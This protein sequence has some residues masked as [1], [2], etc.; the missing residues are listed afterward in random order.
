MIL[1]RRR[2]LPVLALLVV[3]GCRLVDQTTF[4]KE[5]G[6]PPVIP[7]VPSPPPA[8]PE[9]PPALLTIPLSPE[10]DWAGVLRQAVASAVQRKPT[11]V[12]DVAAIVPA[13]GTPEEQVA[14][15]TTASE[16]ASRIARA[17]E[18]AGIPPARVNLSARTAAGLAASEVR[19]YVR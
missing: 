3:P 9:G 4:D 1:R 7:P 18:A 8:A 19:V 12:F 16:P 6:K 2:V 17:I 14:A 5:A 10:P 11:V 15:V 13:R